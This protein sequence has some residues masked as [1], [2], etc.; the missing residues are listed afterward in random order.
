[1][2][3]PRCLL[4]FAIFLATFTACVTP[5]PEPTG[6]PGEVVRVLR[7]PLDRAW[8]ETVAAIHETGVVV[9]HA[10]RPDKARGTIQTKELRVDLVW[11]PGGETTEATVRYFDSDS[12]RARARG[13]GLLNSIVDRL[14]R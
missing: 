13:E 14:E 10:Q 11:L 8:R 5:E 7:A 1:M 4:I 9:P 12:L 3:F 6:P 2:L